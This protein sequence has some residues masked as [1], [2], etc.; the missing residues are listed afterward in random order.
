MHARASVVFAIQNWLGESAEAKKTSSQ[1]A[2]FSVG[3]SSECCSLYSKGRFMLTY[4]SYGA[5]CCRSPLVSHPSLS[6]HGFRQ[7]YLPLFLPPPSV[8]GQ[9]GTSTEAPAAAA[10]SNGFL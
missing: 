6:T 5:R 8:P 9:A 3:M 10:P 1:P 2:Y 4:I 7:T